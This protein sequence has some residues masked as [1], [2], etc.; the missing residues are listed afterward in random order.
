MCGPADSVSVPSPTAESGQFSSA[1]DFTELE[2]LT[3]ALKMAEW[4]SSLRQAPFA[5]AYIRYSIGD[6]A[7]I[8]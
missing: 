7:P 6:P 2:V 3:A 1:D 5:P 4:V 8:P